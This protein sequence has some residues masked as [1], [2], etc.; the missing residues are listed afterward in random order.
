VQFAVVTTN[1]QAALPGAAYT[2]V[3]NGLGSGA[4]ALERALHL[5]TTSTPP[6]EQAPA[7]V[8]PPVEIFTPAPPSREAEAL[9]RQFALTRSSA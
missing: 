7:V 5:T 2:A 1:A 8:V 9:L 6:D 4:Q 3:A